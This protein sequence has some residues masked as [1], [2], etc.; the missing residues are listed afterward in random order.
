MFIILNKMIPIVCV[1]FLL[2]CTSANKHNA[3]EKFKTGT[4][5]YNIRNPNGQIGRTFLINRNDSIQ[6]ETDKASGETS[7]LSVTWIDKCTYALRILEST[8]NFPDSIQKLR[9]K[10]PI[11]NTILS[12][13]ATYC[14]FEARREGI[15]YILIDTLWIKQ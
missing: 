12:T 8:F 6:I 13:T 15:N 2:A 7:K 9:K 3:C 4:F 5:I 11:K 10:V 14:I 1:I